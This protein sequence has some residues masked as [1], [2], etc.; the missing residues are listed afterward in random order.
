MLLLQQLLHKEKNWKEMN[1]LDYNFFITEGKK[2]FDKDFDSYL[3]LKSF[4]NSFKIILP[5]PTENEL[6]MFRMCI[7]EGFFLRNSV[8]FF[9]P[10]FTYVNFEK[11]CIIWPDY[12]LSSSSSSE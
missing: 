7:R 11:D 6:E 3:D 1:F 9:Y 4:V 12:C 10:A 2:L 5:T 8:W